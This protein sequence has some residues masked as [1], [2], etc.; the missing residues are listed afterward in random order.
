[1]SIFGLN[2][3]FKT[4]LWQHPAEETSKRFSL[5]ISFLCFWQYISR[6]ALV[7]R[8]LP[9]PEK[10]LVV[11]LHSGIVLFAKCCILDVWQCFEYASVSITAYK[12]VQWSYSMYIQN[13]GLFRNLF[14]Q[15]YAGIFKNIQHY[16]GI[17][18]NI[19]TLLW[20]IQDYSGMFTNL[21]YSKSC[22]I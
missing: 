5:G 13:S 19:E 17:F 14:I 8:N 9:C 11:C 18:T 16:L 20:H 15:V 1:M 10:F 4:Y 22:H 6:S 2:F 7:Q 3:E 12:F 21:S